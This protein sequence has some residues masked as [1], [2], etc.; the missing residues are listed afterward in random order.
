M[1]TPGNRFDPKARLLHWLMAPLVLAMLFIGI[2]MVS[3]TSTAYALLLAIHKPLGAI[4]LVLVLLRIMVRLRHRPP[5]LPADMPRWQQRA[6]L[7]SH[8]LLYA[9]LLAM[10]LVGWAMLSAAGYPVVMPIAPH[11]PALFAWLRS[12][13]HWLAL[14]LFAVILLHLAAALFHG[15]VR[16]DGVLSSMASWQRREDD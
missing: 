15:L 7:L 3:T 16:R 13:H 2:G 9:L 5:P 1:K 11:D 12:A 10:P 6:A 8:W 4:L 14:L